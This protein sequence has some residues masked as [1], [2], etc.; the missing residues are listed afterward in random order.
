MCCALSTL[1]PVSR[2]GAQHGRPMGWVS[3]QEE[4]NIQPAIAN[5]EPEWRRWKRNAKEAGVAVR[6]R[7]IQA[8]DSIMWPSNRN[9][10][11]KTQ[12]RATKS[13]AQP[14]TERHEAT[15]VNPATQNRAVG[16]FV[17]NSNLSPQRTPHSDTLSPLTRYGRASRRTP[18]S[19]LRRWPRAFRL[20]LPGPHPSWHPRAVQ[21]NRTSP[22]GAGTL[23]SRAL[24]VSSNSSF[25][26]RSNVGVIER[27]FGRASVGGTPL[28][29]ISNPP[30]PRKFP[31]CPAPLA[32][33]NPAAQKKMLDARPCQE[34]D[35]HKRKR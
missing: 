1:F 15:L 11:K 33:G 22:P 30:L 7:M 28:P 8:A 18:C 31:L 23:H 17:T 19:I 34:S 3:N 32:Q 14:T 21:G 26:P 27:L 20:R 10:A 2:R 25:T 6:L 9:G 29:N 13:A 16:C 12:D 24:D 35:V 5:N 4:P